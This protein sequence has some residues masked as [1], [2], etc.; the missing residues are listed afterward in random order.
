MHHVQGHLAAGRMVRPSW[1]VMTLNNLNMD[2][3]PLLQVGIHFHPLHSEKSLCRQNL[4][5]KVPVKI[6]KEA[7][8][9]TCSVSGLFS[10]SNPPSAAGD[11][12]AHT[13]SSSAQGG[14]KPL[15]K[16]F[17]FL[18]NSDTMSDGWTELSVPIRA[19]AI[20][21]VLNCRFGGDPKSSVS[22]NFGLFSRSE[23]ASSVRPAS[24]DPPL[25]VGVTNETRVRVLLVVA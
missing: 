22:T 8:F 10:F 14:R 17:T 4:H 5:L 20:S 23:S 3:I 25:S 1:L 7:L 9:N 21:A 11:A 2:T 19:S 12:A 16:S 13:A 18:G 15:W 24:A 6:C